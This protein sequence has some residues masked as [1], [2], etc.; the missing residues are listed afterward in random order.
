MQLGVR[1]AHTP[2]PAPLV[3]P[4]GRAPGTPPALHW[5][6]PAAGRQSTP[7]RSGCTRSLLHAWGHTCM[8]RDCVRQRPAT[9]L[10][11]RAR[12]SES[13]SASASA[14]LRG[15]GCE[16]VS[17]CDCCCCRCCRCCVCHMHKS[18]WCPLWWSVTESPL[19]QDVQCPCLLL[20][21]HAPSS[22]RRSDEE[23]YELW[24]SQAPGKPHPPGHAREN[25]QATPRQVWREACKLWNM[26][27]PRPWDQYIYS[28][29]VHVIP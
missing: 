15:C 17:K 26:G 27:R 2:G 29:I 3:D 14:R 13:A 21:P 11:H 5:P 23:G 16:D 1:V 24:R 12:A 6:A 19:A 9:R 20:R 8:F 10:V 25:K 22:A 28:G 4:R 18:L 7:R